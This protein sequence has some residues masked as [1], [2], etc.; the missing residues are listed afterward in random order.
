MQTHVPSPA[1][2]QVVQ[3]GGPLVLL[4]DTRSNTGVGGWCRGCCGAL[5]CWAMGAV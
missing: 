4:G 5:L 2:A 1:A 3:L